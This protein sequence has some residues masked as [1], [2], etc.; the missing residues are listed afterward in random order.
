METERQTIQEFIAKHKIAMKFQSVP[1]NPHWVEGENLPSAPSYLRANY[2]LG[3]LHYFV[4]L[5]IE[6]Y[7]NAPKTF[8]LYFSM[9]Y[10]IFPEY[11][12][13]KNAK[14][15]K[16]RRPKIEDI[17]DCMI[18]E[19]YVLDYGNWVD[20]S[21]ELGY[22]IKSHKD[23]QKLEASYNISKSQAEKFKAFLGEPAYNELINET[24]RL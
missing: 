12:T 5:S 1:E 20:Y 13:F 3:F 10:K 22:E 2:K 21:L 18:S 7:P 14:E 9:G 6:Q 15:R 11:E 4:T 24:E 23:A 17:L 8:T 19:S 16:E